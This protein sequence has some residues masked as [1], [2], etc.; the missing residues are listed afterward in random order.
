MTND[1]EFWKAINDADFTQPE[2]ITHKVY[3][4]AQTGKIIEI[5]TEEREH[6]FITVS[7]EESV[8]VE[9]GKYKVRNGQLYNVAFSNIDVLNLEMKE[10][11]R[12]KTV[13]NNM[14]LLDDNSIEDTDSYDTKSI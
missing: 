12:F 9:N 3:Y 5:T 14:L 11:G 4:D 7:F 13:K 10:N 1:E 6:E 2:P 8:A